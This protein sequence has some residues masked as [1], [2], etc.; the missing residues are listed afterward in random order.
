[1]RKRVLSVL[2]TLCM[3]LTLLPV[4]ALAAEPQNGIESAV[5]AYNEY[6]Y[7][8][9]GGNGQLTV[10]TEGNTVYIGG[11]VTAAKSGLRLEPEDTGIRNIVWNASLSGNSNS[12]M[13][14][15]WYGN[16]DITVNGKIENETGAALLLDTGN[17]NYNELT[18]ASRGVLRGGTNG[19]T[20]AG[21]GGP[22]SIEVNG[23][24]EGGT[25][26]IDATS[27]LVSRIIVSG[28]SAKVTGG[29]VGIDVDTE[30]YNRQGTDITVNRGIISGGNLGIALNTV[31]QGSIT[32]D[33][34]GEINGGIA[35]NASS[36]YE[37]EGVEI[38]VNNGII[39]AEN[40][41]AIAMYLSGSSIEVRGNGVVVSAGA[42]AIVAGFE[43]YPSWVEPGSISLSTYSGS[44]L[45]GCGS[46]VYSV[47]QAMVL[48]KLDGVSVL[49]NDSL[50]DT[51]EKYSTE[52][53]VAVNPEGATAWW[54]DSYVNSYGYIAWR[55]SDNTQGSARIPGV[56]VVEGSISAPTFTITLDPNGGTL[57]AGA[58]D[59]Y[60]TD[61]NGRLVND[62]KPLPTPIRDGYAFLGW[63]WND[64]KVL[65]GSASTTIF[66]EDAT[67]V[68]KWEKN[69]V[70]GHI[71]FTLKNSEAAYTGQGF[72]LN[73]FANPATYTGTGAAPTFT[74][75]L[76]KDN[77]AAQ[78]VTLNSTVTEAGSYTL[79]ATT[80]VNGMTG[81][82]S[83][84]FVIEKADRTITVEALPELYVGGATAQVKVTDTAPETESRTYTYATSDEK[85]A[86]VSSTGVVTP[87]GEGTATITVTAPATANY[88]EAAATAT[89]K[90]SALPGQEVSFAK[91]G[92]Q[93]ATYG[94]AFENAATNA[95]A[96]GDQEL[97][98]D[99]S[100]KEV[101]T[102]DNTGKVTILGAGETTIS[103]TADGVDGKYAATTKSYK[104][105]VSPKAIT[106][107]AEAV[108]K[109][110]DGTT[111][112]EV[113][114]TFDG[115]VNG[116]TTVAYEAK[117]VFDDPNAGTGKT[118]TVTITLNTP[119]YTLTNGTITLEN[120]VITKAPA[121]VIEDWTL[122]VR[123][124]D[125]AEK[126]F[127]LS[128]LMPVNAGD[129]EVALTEEAV[130]GDAIYSV[131]EDT[132]VYQLAED[133]TEDDVQSIEVP[134]T[135]ASQNYE[136]VTVT[137]VLRITDKYVP[138]ISV[139]DIITT[140]TGKDVADSEIKGTAS[141][142][143]IWSFLAN[144]ALINVKDSGN[145]IVVFT[146]SDLDVYETVKDTVLVTIN[147]A[148][149]D[150]EPSY[151]AIT[152]SGHTLADAALNKG[153][154]AIRGAIV[155]DDGDDTVVEANTAYG[156]TFTPEDTDNYKILTGTITPY[157][158]SS[159]GG[160]GSGSSSTTRYSVT[161]KNSDNG[162]VE[163][164]VSR[165]AKGDTV[166]LTV[167]PDKG[168]VLDTLT[169]TAANGDKINLNRGSN[170]R[171]T[172]E[173]P[174]SRVTVK[175]TFVEE[176]GEEAA[177]PFVDV[178]AGDWFYDAVVYV[179]D[180]GLM[181]GTAATTF[182]PN[183]GTTRGMIATIL[184]RLAGSPNGGANP[185]TD[186][187]G[188]DYYAE[189]VAWA[190]GEGIVGG[191]GNGVF[192]ANDPITREQ[193]A[194]MMYRYAQY[195]GYE[196]SQRSAQL[197]SYADYASISDWA[198][199]AVSWANAVGLMNGR[200]ATT[201]VPTGTI[202][203]AEAATILMQFGENVQK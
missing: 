110:F 195:A 52:D 180:N 191:Y 25:N 122:P 86:T 16:V 175:A 129:L 113:S 27:G 154:I 102:V 61:T 76:S 189:A 162:D 187:S 26:G 14:Q 106:A 171:Y 136:D 17:L 78:T 163:A 58:S 193:M 29:S 88:K 181:S 152:G 92:D 77:G 130:G 8:R 103:V 133:L 3:V 139:E 107:A 18:V 164:N 41:A 35:S 44:F 6:L 151:T 141:V 118:V 38:V 93:T 24:V 2:M 156:W 173:M 99:S 32:V 69:D 116:E 170:G 22:C 132:F 47:N 177:E 149:P 115:L 143:G 126:T 184:W 37:G 121:P 31:Y 198:V 33:N 36:M 114:V 53:I 11:T 190:A 182:G 39:C 62:N 1:M 112:A 48:R 13:L 159:G 165:A 178:S 65:P 203:R 155:W 172:F 153:T 95:T 108:E 67:L 128:G 134:V 9:N 186:V 176:G 104:L 51:Y 15:I 123:F 117:A 21:D 140:Y 157:V 72:A 70:A 174:A 7:N 68:A 109:V 83:V 142:E 54:S 150:G 89:V 56:K 57:P 201:I 50:K 199:E 98:Y 40:R 91:E 145:K 82:K 60:E 28:S 196:T 42:P 125:T 73:Y 20:Y 74:Y 84:T 202:T 169:V 127:D 49:L 137:M 148:D 101:A 96:D 138:V 161:V 111:D 59:T 120:G 79:T 81:S 71:N 100:N 105:T 19:V 160:S 75:T 147:K 146:P 167:T 135:V 94:D 194:L 80:T 168:Y 46:I 5:E 131:R 45:A 197:S 12:P 43:K 23:I 192:G 85:V 188:S 34:I 4:S 55:N 30:G 179:Y 158:R 90:V 10:R 64:Q 144:Q 200:T 63:Y 183:V 87:V 66:S 124:D 97:T 185:F 119:N 166:T